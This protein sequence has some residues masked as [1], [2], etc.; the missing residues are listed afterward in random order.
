MHAYTQ[1][2]NY[3]QSVH[4]CII[5]ADRQTDIYTIGEVYYYYIILYC[6]NTHALI[7]AFGNARTVAN[8]NSSRFGKFILVQFKENGAYHG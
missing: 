6:I 3:V 4:N 5:H 2:I 8:N 7:Q 1:I